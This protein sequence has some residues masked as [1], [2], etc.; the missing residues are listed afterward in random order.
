VDLNNLETILAGQPAYRADQAREA[1]FKLLAN[2]WNEV[3]ALPKELRVKLNQDCPLAID[4]RIF[5]SREGDS[6]KALLAL[7]DG[8][9]IETVLMRHSD[10]RNTVC[11]SS[12]VGCPM[13]CKFC[14]TGKLG[15]KRNLT[16]MEIIKQ[17]LLFSR[18]LKKENRRVGSV[19]FMGM[20]EPFLNYDN[21]M[22]AIRMMNDE[23]GLGIGARHIS[24]STVGVVEGIEKLIDEPLQVNLAV[25]L[26]APNDDLRLKMMPADAKYP[27]GT[28]F[29]AV[30]RYV[31][32]TNRRVM[33][34]YIM[35]DRLNDSDEYARELVALIK[36]RL[37][38]KLAFVN[39]ISYNPTG[40]FYPSSS[41]RV[42]KFKEILEDA[43][44]E[45]TQ[46][47]R[48]GRGIK[49]ACGQLAPKITNPY[50]C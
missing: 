39:L 38:L 46:R 41:S 6:T 36:G 32:N 24:I 25:S 22:A 28:I 7:D 5:N 4:T 23:N 21:V 37:S 16:A 40:D 31:K 17:V 12:Q 44:V 19:V 1:V 45:V 14:A 43:N 42:K 8:S 10:D 48:F 49:A 47:Y 27:I 34:E 2:D 29:T 11:V 15:F 18:I 35:I 26:H 9:E 3:R 30:L 50:V 13:G 20:G 33:F